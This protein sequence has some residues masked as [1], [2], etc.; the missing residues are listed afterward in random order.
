MNL[1][2]L[3]HLGQEPFLQDFGIPFFQISL[4]GGPISAR[5]IELTVGPPECFNNHAMFGEAKA[6]P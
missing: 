1:I 5:D 2:R 6:T 3:S 4:T